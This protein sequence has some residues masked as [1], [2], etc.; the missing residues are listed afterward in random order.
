MWF[1][2]THTAFISLLVPFNGVSF[3]KSWNKIWQ[4]GLRIHLSAA[5]DVLLLSLG[6]QPSLGLGLL[7]K[8]RLNF[9]EASQQFSFLQGRVVSPTPDP[10]PGGPGRC[11]YILQRQDVYPFSR[12]LRHAW[13]TVGLFL[14]PG[15]HT[16]MWCTY[17]RQTVRPDKP[18][19][20]GAD[21]PVPGVQSGPRIK[22]VTVKDTNR[23]GIII[24]FLYCP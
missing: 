21:S 14:F 2:L 10:H 16:G 1:R 17:L 5:S 20:S 23:V 24:L 12:L 18:G 13:V 11:I 6:P 7:H 8:I 9:L 22:A 15:H 19:R 3:F 4:F